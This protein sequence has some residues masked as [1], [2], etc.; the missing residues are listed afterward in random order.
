MALIK[1]KCPYC[2]LTDREPKR[3]VGKSKKAYHI[4]VNPTYG[5][6]CET[7]AKNILRKYGTLD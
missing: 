5:E 6:S 1:S 3:K 7:R 4:K 2:G